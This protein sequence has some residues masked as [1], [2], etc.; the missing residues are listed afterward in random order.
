M[1]DVGSVDAPRQKQERLS[2]TAHAQHHSAISFAAI[3]CYLAMITSHANST[4]DRAGASP[5]YGSPL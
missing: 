4:V 3:H 2:L 1:V 5:P